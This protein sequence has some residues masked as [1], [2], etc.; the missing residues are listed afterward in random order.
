MEWFC[1]LPVQTQ[2]EIVQRMNALAEILLQSGYPE[3]GST[4]SRAGLFQKEGANTKRICLR[5]G[6]GRVASVMKAAGPQTSPWPMAGKRRGLG[7][8]P[9]PWLENGGASDEPLAHGRKAA[10][11]EMGPWL[12]AGNQPGLRE[13]F[14]TRSR[15]AARIR[16]GTYRQK[17][18]RQKVPGG[19]SCQDAKVYLRAY[20]SNTWLKA[21]SPYL[22][23][24]RYWWVSKLLRLTSIMATAI[25]EQWS[26]TRS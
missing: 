11:P 3:A 6:E 14:A 15:T 8:A 21:L 2:Q 9:G 4:F 26:E 22:T 13:G 10:G 16:I 12:V 1:A 25:L 18:P 17:H 23:A 7:W 20:W 19:V 24:L 5:K